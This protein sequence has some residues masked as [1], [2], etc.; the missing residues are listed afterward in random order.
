MLMRTDVERSKQNVGLLRCYFDFCSSWSIRA[1][2]FIF[3]VDCPI[4][5]S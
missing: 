5:M 2:G 3:V 4:K 1:T